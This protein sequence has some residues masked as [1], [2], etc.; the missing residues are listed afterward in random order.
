M[1]RG[2][3]DLRPIGLHG[4]ILMATVDARLPERRIQV[5]PVGEAGEEH[6]GKHEQLH[7]LVRS[8]LRSVYGSRSVV[9][10]FCTSHQVSPVY[11]VLRT[12]GLYDAPPRN[13]FGTSGPPAVAAR[14]SRS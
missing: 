11:P 5:D 14:I 4:L 13:G 12:H 1:S 10:V 9:G 2:T 8:A 6:L 3:C 7:L